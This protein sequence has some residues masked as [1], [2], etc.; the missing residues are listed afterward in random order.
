MLRNSY[1]LILASRSPR[2][3]QLLAE[4]G[5]SFTV[6]TKDTEETVPDYVAPSDT[7]AYLAEKKALAFR[8][9]LNERQ[10]VL[11]ADTVVIVGEEILNKPADEQQATAMLQM[12]SGNTHRVV[13]GVCLMTARRLIVCSDTANVHF[14]PL[15]DEEI[16]YY[17]TRYRPFD[18]AG[19]YGI[20]E[21]IGM[22]G[23]TK[24]EGSFFTVMGLPT[25][26]VYDMIGQINAGN[27]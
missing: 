6:Q 5:F 26:L 23:I 21:W 20:Q 1:E 2:R 9:D 16:R 3:R 15:T 19:A 17:V 14:R 8:K 12:L 18:K 4:L 24:I 7:A 22:I 10:A 27:S 25:H 11:A 13:T